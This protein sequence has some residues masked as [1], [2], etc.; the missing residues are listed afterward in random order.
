MADYLATLAKGMFGD[1]G[2]AVLNALAYPNVRPNDPTFDNGPGIGAVITLATASAGEV[3]NATD[4]GGCVFVPPGI[5]YWSG[6]LFVPK[7]TDFRGGG[8]G[9]TVFRPLD[10]TA[11]IVVGD[12]V[13]INQRGGYVGDFTI[14]CPIDAPVNSPELLYIG[15]VVQRQFANINVVYGGRDGI[16]VEGA[17]NCAFI[18]VEAEHCGTDGIGCGLVLDLGAGN[19]AFMRC[20]FNSCDE[21][22]VKIVQSTA[23]P[24]GAFTVPT[25][26][27]FF[28]CVIE[29]L[30][31]NGVGLVYHGNGRGN[32][33]ELCD[34]STQPNEWT[35]TLVTA[36]RD[37]LTKGSGLLRFIDCAFSGTTAYSTVFDVQSDPSAG[38]TLVLGGFNFYEN[39]SQ[40]YYIDDNSSIELDGSNNEPNASN[41][42]T[43]FANAGGGTSAYW[44]RVRRTVHNQLFLRA[45]TSAHSAFSYFVAGETYSRLE[46]IAGVMRL[47]DGATADVATI[48]KSSNGGLHTLLSSRAIQVSNTPVQWSAGAGAPASA[49]ST[50]S[51]YGRSDGAIDTAHY[52]RAAST[53]FPVQPIHSGTTGSRP[54]VTTAGFQYFDT[55]LGKP[56]WWKASASVWVDAT[57]ATV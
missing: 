13:D 50:G 45:P 7:Y 19:N 3:Y 24:S 39:H 1:R 46:L 53:W 57:G 34:L 37:D 32:A 56:V 36:R 18:G 21:Y 51:N 54:T 11:R 22:N 12:L 9:L 10:D 23:S 28:G 15:K 14:S 16:R 2:G 41:V 6:D 52:I 8:K 40:L 33:F 44:T 5:Y 4:G 30:N 29:R 31:P 17:Q 43:I 35:N 55:T 20:E 25:S 27:R 38:T 48:Q 26:N 42:T 47:T 49:G